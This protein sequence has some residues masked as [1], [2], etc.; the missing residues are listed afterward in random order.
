[1]IEMSWFLGA[2]F[3]P[4]REYPRKSGLARH[5]LRDTT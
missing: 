1:M 2:E 4:A 3:G 5:L